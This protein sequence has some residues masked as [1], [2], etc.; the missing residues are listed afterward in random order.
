SSAT[1]SGSFGGPNAVGSQLEEGEQEKDPF[2]ALDLL[3]P[4]LD[5][6][7]KVREK[8]GIH[9]GGDYSSLGS[10][11][12]D[13]L[14]DDGAAAGMVRFFGSWDLVD[15]DGDHPGAFVW[16]VEHRHGYT[17]VPPSGLGFE[18]GYVGLLGPPFSDQGWRTTN[19]YWR[20]RFAKGRFA[21]TAGFLDSTDYVDA[22]AMASP[23]LHFTNLAFSTGS[24]SIA[25]PNDAMLGIAAGG[26]LTENL[27]AIAGFGDANG[28]P[29]DPFDGFESFFKDNE[30]FKSF[31]IGWS[32]SHERLLLDNV[33]VTLW[34]VD[35]REAAAT[36]SGWGVNLSASTYVD[37]RWMLFLRA[38]WAKDGG[39]LLDRSVSAGIGYQVV[40]GRGLLGAAV[41]WGRPNKDTFGPGLGSQWTF[42][43]FYRWQVLK[44][45]AI[46]PDV[47]LLV[48]PA[49]NPD[50]SVIWILGLR[51]RYAL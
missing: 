39:S 37:D 49:Q 15:R 50:K 43:A 19:L 10:W 32:R 24:A 20:Q 18:A 44:Q 25:L 33:H 6:K 38:G 29:E 3:Q 51:L 28:D 1:A 26:M 17:D 21:V 23:W 41:N 45:L 4:Y 34:H 11:A 48:D 13:S 47:Q 46:T 5:W 42:E 8:T 27:Y 35:S 14:G 2:F 22:Y 7:A 12:S 31:E 36:P 40:P 9:F 16:K 30:Y